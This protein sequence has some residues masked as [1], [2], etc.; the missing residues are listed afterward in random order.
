M[1]TNVILLSSLGCKVSC[2]FIIAF[3]YSFRLPLCVQDPVSSSPP[4]KTNVK[5]HHK[6]HQYPSIFSLLWGEK[7]EF[8][9]IPLN[10]NC[11]GNLFKTISG[12]QC[13]YTINTTPANDPNYIGVF[14][15]SKLLNLIGCITWSLPHFTTISGSEIC[16]L[17]I[18]WYYIA[19]MFRWGFHN[20][21]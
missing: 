9:S 19:V 11:Q 15:L 4:T 13:L 10:S 6:N 21:C 3:I 5:F 14:Y 16:S 12:S 8:S 2:E 1:Y 18:I 20:Q 7:N 17:I